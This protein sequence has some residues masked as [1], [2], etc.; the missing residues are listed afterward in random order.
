MKLAP[1]VDFYLSVR[2][3]SLTV[4]CELFAFCENKIKCSVK[5]YHGVVTTIPS[6]G[7]ESNKQKCFLCAIVGTK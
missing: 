3:A 6:I 5:P 2:I 4:T 1:M 7:F